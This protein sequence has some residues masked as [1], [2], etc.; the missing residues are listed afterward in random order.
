MGYSWDIPPQTVIE[1]DVMACFTQDLVRISWKPG[2]HS[3]HR[4]NH[5]WRYRIALD[6]SC[7]G[8]DSGSAGMIMVVLQVVMAA[9]QA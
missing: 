3:R 1:L 9:V 8:G 4:Q 6:G 2:Q 5:W 7:A